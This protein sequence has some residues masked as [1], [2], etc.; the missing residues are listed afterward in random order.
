[1][2]KI[3]FY[4]SLIA[5]LIVLVFSLFS[6]TKPPQ[7]IPAKKHKVYECIEITSSVEDLIKHLNEQ[8][9][10]IDRF[11]L[12][13]NQ[14]HLLEEETSSQCSH[15]KAKLKDFEDKIIYVVLPKLSS[16]N[17]GM[18]KEFF[19]KNQYLKALDDCE[20]NDL[21]IFT[22]LNTKID[23]KE[24]YKAI[25]M[26]EQRPNE[27]FLL[28]SKHTNASHTH[29]PTYITTYNNAKKELPATIEKQALSK[30]THFNW[31]QFFFPITLNKASIQ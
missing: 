11:V 13:E 17:Y 25:A 30:Q 29:Q 6:V 27:V 22:H 31:K 10:I 5:V 21:V 18:A 7:H 19:L 15:L 9:P 4:I 1:M 16:I 2:L 28:H 14:E 20:E 24:L 8:N 23:L 3:R 26:L 12:L